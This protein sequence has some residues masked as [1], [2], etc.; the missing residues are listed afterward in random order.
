LYVLVPYYN[1]IQEEHDP[2]GDDENG[3]D[4]D[5]DGPDYDAFQWEK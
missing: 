1:Q 2:F 5:D 3:G 4:Y